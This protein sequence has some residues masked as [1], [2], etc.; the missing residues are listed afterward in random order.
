MSGTGAPRN[1]TYAKKEVVGWPISLY[2]TGEDVE[3]LTLFWKAK[4][5][6]DEPE[7]HELTK[8]AKQAAKI[9]IH[10]LLLDLKESENKNEQA[11]MEQ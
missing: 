6:G 8:L 5:P 10:R 7:R 4:H 2:L 9:G 3:V 11:D 1:N